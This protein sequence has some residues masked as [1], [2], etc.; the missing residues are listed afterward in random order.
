M[1]EALVRPLHPVPLAVSVVAALAVAWL[2]RPGTLGGLVF[3]TATFFVLRY[4]C[5]IVEHRAWGRDSDGIGDWRA[6]NQGFAQPLQIAGLV[7]VLAIGLGIAGHAGGAAGGSLALALINFAAPA[8][9]LV[10]VL[11]QGLLD[12]LNP[13]RPAAVIRTIGFDYLAACFVL[14]LFSLAGNMLLDVLLNASHP[15]LRLFIYSAASFYYI[16]A[17]FYVLAWLVQRHR[18]ELIG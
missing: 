6:F 3:V 10:I 15:V 4:G 17:V 12:A 9:V 16:L 2:Y 18:D 13:A 14:A 11:G 5:L 7:V 8:C 1:I